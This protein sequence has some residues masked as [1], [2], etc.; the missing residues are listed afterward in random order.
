MT[1]SLF[2]S[3]LLYSRVLSLSSFPFFSFSLSSSCLGKENRNFWFFFKKKK[4]IMII[5]TSESKVK[6]GTGKLPVSLLK[7]S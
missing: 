3:L 5:E 2:P 7:G 1:S 4:K 6:P